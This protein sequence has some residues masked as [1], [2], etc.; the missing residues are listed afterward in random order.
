[1]A[2]TDYGVK[3]CEYCGKAFEPPIPDDW[4][5][6][7]QINYRRAWVCSW[8]C[9]RAAERTGELPHGA[10]E[11]DR[12]RA[13]KKKNYVS[14]SRGGLMFAVSQ[15]GMTSG[16]VSVKAG[17]TRT[18]ISSTLRRKDPPA[19]IPREVAERIA[20]ICGVSPSVIIKEEVEHAPG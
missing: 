4:V 2:K 5:Y 16:T 6:R 7:V 11:K 15:S 19:R 18:Y 14:I 12:P 1:M 10:R 3:V 9:L 20:E 17:K 8:S 13:P